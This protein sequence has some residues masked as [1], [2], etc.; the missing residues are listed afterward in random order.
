MGSELNSGGR[1]PTASSVT[2]NSNRAYCGLANRTGTARLVSA[3]SS[4]PAGLTEAASNDGA[5]N[6]T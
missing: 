5:S 3:G 4:T 6:V 2:A 1:L